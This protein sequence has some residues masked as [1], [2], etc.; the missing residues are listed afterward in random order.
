VTSEQPESFRC[1]SRYF[2]DQQEYRDWFFIR[3][4]GFGAWYVR[5]VPR[6]TIANNRQVAN[7]QAAIFPEFFFQVRNRQGRAVAYLATAAGYWSGDPASL[8]DMT[9]VNDWPAIATHKM[10]PVAAAHV[11][12]CEV[13]GRP[14]LFA[15]IKNQVRARRLPGANTMFLLAMTVHPDFHRHHL[16]TL[17]MDA[18]QTSARQLGFEHVAG[19]FRPS[20]YG[21]YKAERRVAHSV[22]LFEE[23][24]R[25]DNGQ[26]LPL[27]PWLR[28]VVRKGVKLLRMEPRSFSVS[29]S[30][31]KFEAFRRSHRPDAWY[32]PSPNVWECG[33]TCTWY[34]DPSRRSV[35]AVE[36]NYWGCFDLGRT[37]APVIGPVI[38]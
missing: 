11:L 26:G 35:L 3:S 21:A 5:P 9:Y 27:D 15:P 1:E 36:P 32:S 13:L 17:L 30:I 25:L 28:N 16:P 38:E 12:C 31:A 20:G 37:D 4:S 22:A 18:A 10:A 23:Y 6:P 7:A 33:E 8:H 29:G 24:C 2:R 14:E 34:V 19:A